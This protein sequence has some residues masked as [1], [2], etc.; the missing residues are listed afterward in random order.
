MNKVKKM[1]PSFKL[2]LKAEFEGPYPAT[3]MIVWHKD[4]IKEG[5]VLIMR[6]N[7][8]YGLALPGGMCEN[9]L[10]YLQN[11]KKEMREEISLKVKIFD[12]YLLRPIVLSESNQDVRA[13]ISSHVYVGRGFGNLKAND[14]A[15][16]ARIFSLEEICELIKKP[17]LKAGTKP[18]NF[19]DGWSM[20]H[21]KVALATYFF[22]LI[23]G[24]TNNIINWKPSEEQKSI[25]YSI[26][27][28]YRDKIE[29]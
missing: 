18:D 11:S 27:D 10:N 13:H 25:I 8:P 21:Y 14:D 7:F 6:E 16:K 4:K 3:D 23:E 19:E 12:E 28:S 26:V 1:Y 29:K 2:Y 22:D 17:V 20:P 24:R 15:K 9:G 5:I